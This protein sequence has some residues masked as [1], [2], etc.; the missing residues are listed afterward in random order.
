VF[1]EYSLRIISGILRTGKNLKN[2]FGLSAPKSFVFV[3]IS[4]SKHY[5]HNKMTEK[6]Y[7]TGISIIKIWP[8][9]LHLTRFYEYSKNVKMKIP[10][11][12]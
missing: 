8:G 1:L 4:F 2:R 9:N 5:S 7:C 3:R 12:K 10:K 6:Y 11:W